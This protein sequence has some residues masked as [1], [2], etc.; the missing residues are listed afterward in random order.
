MIVMPSLRMTGWKP[1]I[2]V[3]G[4][5]GG[6]GNAVNN[7]IA[8]NLSG[9][10]FIAANTDAQALAMS[11]AQHIVQLGVTATEGLGAGSLPELGRAAAEESI[12]Q[13]MAHLADTQMCF[14]TAGMGGGTGTG[15][16]PVIAHAARQSGILTVAVV[17]EPFGFEGTHRARQARQGIEQLIDAAD[18]VIVVPN[19]SLFRLSDRQTTL[20][21]AFSMA[22][23]ILYSGVMSIV[24]LITKE[25][26][27]NL[28]FAD[29]RSVMKDMGPAVMA[30]GEA[31]GPGRATDAAKAA[32]ENPLFGEATLR[33][34]RGILVSIAA[35][36]ELTLFEVDEAASCIR[37]QVDADA[38][39][40]LGARFDGSLDDKL[41][42][43]VI[44]TGLRRPADV[45]MLAEHAQKPILVHA[46]K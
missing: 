26:L 28:D 4:V 9:V 8:R 5:G 22:D 37:D 2:T 10:E 24:E 17:T 14:V 43:S 34:A 44:A 3:T 16:A 6:G 20:E 46:V 31:S 42:V 1:K 19:Q 35:A 23:S 30:T 21:T 27:I 18:T 39:I 36:R 11:K 32:V 15:A 38:E 13:I 33:G 45:V 29:V 25:G 12:D 40:I 7:M 41:Q